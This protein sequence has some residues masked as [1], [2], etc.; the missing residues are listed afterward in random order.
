MTYTQHTNDITLTEQDG[1]T[2]LTLDVTITQIGDK[3]KMAAFGMKMGYQA[4]LDKL[5][6]Y[7]SVD[8]G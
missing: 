7:L 4:Q 3:A 5:T 2:T 8:A 6:E 1:R